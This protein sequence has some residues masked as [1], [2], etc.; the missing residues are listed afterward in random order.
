MENKTNHHLLI[1]NPNFETDVDFAFKLN[2]IIL[3][4]TATWHSQSSFLNTIKK[5]INLLHFYLMMTFTIGFVIEII[6]NLDI[7]SSDLVD[8]CTLFV[9]C[10][11]YMIKHVVTVFY[12][13]R[14]RDCYDVLENDWQ[15]ILVGSYEIMKNGAKFGRNLTVYYTMFLAATFFSWHVNALSQRAIVKD[16][17]KYHILGYPCD[18]VFF[19]V[20]LYPYYPLVYIFQL[21]IVTVI[22]AAMCQNCTGAAFIAHATAQC[23]VLIFVL[24]EVSRDVNDSERVDVMLSYVVK[25]HNEVIR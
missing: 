25:K 2:R 24:K 15:F 14:I 8:K 19:D 9:V 6:R 11:G 1:P 18:F 17:V 21:Y 12:S 23:K 16:G 5:L 3:Y 22:L 7:D 20:R 4:Y 10:L 13:A